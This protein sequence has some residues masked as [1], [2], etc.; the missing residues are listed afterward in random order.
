MENGAVQ[1]LMGIQ[2]LN[3]LLFSVSLQ[4]LINCLPD[5]VD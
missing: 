3:E 4:G 5:F 2:G 1:L